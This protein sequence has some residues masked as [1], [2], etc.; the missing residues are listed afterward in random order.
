MSRGIPALV[1]ITGCDVLVAGIVPG[2]CGDGDKCRSCIISLHLGRWGGKRRSWSCDSLM[3]AC[4]VPGPPLS[5]SSRGGSQRFRWA[6]GTKGLCRAPRSPESPSVP[7]TA[8]KHPATAAG[9]ARQPSGCLCSVGSRLCLG[10]GLLRNAGLPSLLPRSERYQSIISSWPQLRIPASPLLLPCSLPRCPTDDARRVSQLGCRRRVQLGPA[11][12]G[13]EGVRAAPCLC[14]G[15]RAV[16]CHCCDVPRR[17][18]WGDLPGGELSLKSQCLFPSTS[19]E[20]PWGK[21]QP[22]QCP[23]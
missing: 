18:E 10:R 5:L 13:Q 3:V 1:H 12:W 9:S 23:F 16:P 22:L 20:K 21:Q 7:A 6:G 2:G 4:P 19:K 11:A 8:G 15:Q 17:R 14:C